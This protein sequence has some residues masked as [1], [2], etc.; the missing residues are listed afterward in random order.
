M[1]RLTHPAL[2]LLWRL[3]L[4]AGWRKIIRSTRTGKGILRLLL[5]LAVLAMTIGP[6]LVFSFVRDA[7][8]AAAARSR[9]E[10]GILLFT[11]LIVLANGPNSGIFFTPPEVDFLFP[12][13]FQRRQLILY[14]LGHQVQA[15]LFGALFLSVAPAAFVPHWVFA[16]LGIAL[17]LQFIQLLS[18]VLGL[19][20]SLVGQA[21]YS[22][23]R[24][25]ALAV[26][27]ALILAAMAQAAAGSAAGG[28]SSMLKEVTNT[29]IVRTVLLPVQVFSRT[30]AAERF[31]PEFLVWAAASLSINA[32]LIALTLRLDADFYERSLAV[33]ERVY[34]ALENARRGQAWMNLAKPS[35]GRWRLPMPA[36]WRGAG[37]IA[38][39]QSV[40][41]LRSSRGVMYVLLIM[42]ATL[43]LIG[44]L[45][46]DSGSG[47]PVAVLIMSTLFTFPQMLQF[48]FRGDIERID[49]LKTLPFSPGA[50][51]VGELIVP[52]VAATIIEWGLV[53]GVGA[54]WT[55]WTTILIV[56]AWV[57]TA[58]LIVFAVENLVFLYFPRRQESKGT[59][60]QASGR[61]MVVNFIKVFAMGVAAGVTAGFGMIAWLVFGGSMT[62]GLVAA[63]CGS[64]TL[65]A[66]LVPQ[67]ARAF[68]VLDPSLE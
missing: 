37:P 22:R 44:Y 5:T 35:A 24:K 1:G 30:I 53:L 52:I 43:G 29:P 8:D 41:A 13:P 28:V 46:R 9:L 32:A 21:A 6:L 4:K 16:F 25:I 23:A 61:Q 14:R 57:P 55:D 67:V 64:A 18:T 15:A 17:V 60:F 59:T 3:Q 20:I 63:W 26:I 31:F 7:P 51:A 39:R 50:I 2:R 56:C 62:A 54:L 48:D 68:R 36:R 38:W 58:N 49:F 34:R 47:I 45:V 42:A 40:S 10:P 65:G 33:S 11:L 66:I 27:A 12:G 19:T